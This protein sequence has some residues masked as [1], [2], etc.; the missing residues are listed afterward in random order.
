[1]LRY[2]DIFPNSHPNHEEEKT[3]ENQVKEVREAWEMGRQRTS[4]VHG[5]HLRPLQASPRLR[6]A[7]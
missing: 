6:G 1:M 2:A 3:W 4:K 5:R 7:F